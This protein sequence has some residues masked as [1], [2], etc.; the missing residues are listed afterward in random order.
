VMAA[1]KKE[2]RRSGLIG[3]SAIIFRLS[4]AKNAHSCVTKLFVFGG[5][6]P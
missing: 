3:G 6:K 2:Q 1:M 4:G 5:E